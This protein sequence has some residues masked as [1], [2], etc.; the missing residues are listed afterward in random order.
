[1]TH[2][3]DRRIFLAGL[4]GGAATVGLAACGAPPLTVPERAATGAAVPGATMRIARPAASAAETLDPASALSAYEYLGAIYNR[5]VRLDRNGETVPDL[6]TEWSSNADATTWTFQLRPGVRFHDGRPL[7]ARDVR[8]TFGHILDPDTGSPQ[9]G[10]LALVDSMDA[11]DATTIRFNLST[12]N[13][14]FPSLLTAYQC[15]VIPEDSAGEIGRTGIG[16]GPFVLESYEP[17]GAGKVRANEDYFDGRPVLDAIEFFSIQDTSARVNALLARQVDLLSQTNLDNATARVVAGSPGT[18]VAR[19]ENAQWYTIPMLATSEEF[20]DPKMREA[21]KLAYDPRRVLATA[22]QGTG[23]PGWDNPV[24][25]QMAAF[26]EVEREY[27]PDKARA[28]LK[29]IG[30]ED[31][32]T[33]IYTSAYEPNFTAIATSFAHQVREAGIRLDI[34]NVS[35]DSYYTQIWMAQPLMVSYWFTGR[36]I[37]QLLN[38]VFRTGSSYNESA[39]SNPQFD[40]LLDAARADTNDATRLAKYQ[41]AQR[42]IVADGA[43]LTPV[44]GDRLVGL[45]TNVVNYDEYGFEFDYLTIGLR[46]ER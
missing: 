8:Y 10:P 3:I 5:V 17:A 4:V 28:L 6:A 20:S 30:R 22:L 11:V 2:P 38:Q 39:W 12:P 14:E 45:S 26:T 46:E 36:P 40:D 21:M 44:F 13:A 24:P 1:M 15:Y 19:V 25:P 37:D 41:D 33:K 7:T 9:A 32:R 23:T 34:T 42:L 31:F 16:T 18:T 35:A 29:E 27:D 43:D